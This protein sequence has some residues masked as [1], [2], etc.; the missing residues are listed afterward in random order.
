MNDACLAV[1]SINAICIVDDV[2][3]VGTRGGTQSGTNIVVSLTRAGIDE[4]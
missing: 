2:D 4:T 1:T 3:V